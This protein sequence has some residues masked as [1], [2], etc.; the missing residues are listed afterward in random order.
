IT[1]TV[2]Q[3][4]PNQVTAQIDSNSQAAWND[5]N[6]LYPSAT[7]SWTITPAQAGSIQDTASNPG[8]SIW[9]GLAYDTKYTARLFVIL[10][11]ATTTPITASIAAPEV[12]T[13]IK[14][15]VNIN[16]VNAT[17]EGTD[18]KL[19]ASTIHDPNITISEYKWKINGVETTINNDNTVNFE[20][21][22]FVKMGA[23]Q[24]KQTVSV[25]VKDSLGDVSS[26]S[27]DIIILRDM[28]IPAPVVSAITGP[29]SGVV[30]EGSQE[31]ITAT[32]TAGSSN[33]ITR[34]I[35]GYEWQ[36]YGAPQAKETTISG[37][38]IWTLPAYDAN[39]TKRKISV[40]AI[41]NAGL[42]SQAMDLD[43]TVK[44]SV[45]SFT[46]TSDAQDTK[47]NAESDIKFTA[48][49]PQAQQANVSKYI[50]FVDS[51]KSAE[52]TGNTWTYQ[53]PAYDGNKRYFNISVKAIKTYGQSEVDG[54]SSLNFFTLKKLWLT[55]DTSSATV[56]G[57]TAE[58]L[59]MP[60][61][62]IN[63][64]AVFNKY[65]QYSHAD[66]T[67]DQVGNITMS[68]HDGYYIIYPRSDR[69]KSPKN[70][71]VLVTVDQNGNAQ[72][73]STSASMGLSQ[74]VVNTYSTVSIAAVCYPDKP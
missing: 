58:G 1:A 45:E 60:R 36:A 64:A 50:W 3:Q 67:V 72:L 26:S 30:Y 24:P 33:N 35:V 16:S 47:V 74:Y 59:P 8:A 10:T 70:T 42:Y 22:P 73:N 31:T 65:S 11:N 32:A 62:S 34:T 52:T 21:N 43:I 69:P 20:L 23:S 44:D 14:T 9:T 61:T 29:N 41:D 27:V 46:L 57:L 51:V 18:I 17:L 19:T 56:K 12:T 2:D 71:G 55:S 54:I 39:N 53:V 15:T 40:R 13:F 38:Y 48:N 37:E 4:K 7:L 68:C 6:S 28:N 49:V 63:I 66:M 25:E 5:F